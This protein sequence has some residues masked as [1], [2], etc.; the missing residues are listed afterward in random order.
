MNRLFCTLTG[1]CKFQ[2]APDTFI[3]KHYMVHYRHTCIKCG[4]VYEWIIPWTSIWH[5]L[6]KSIKD[7]RK[8]E[9]ERF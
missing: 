7:I 3:D 1:G 5:S 8:D 2:G 4:K 6:G 9:D